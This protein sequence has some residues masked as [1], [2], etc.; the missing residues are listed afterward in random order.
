M[1]ARRKRT[2]SPTVGGQLA[3]ER[4]I[5]PFFTQP[6]MWFEGSAPCT[7]CHFANS[8]ES[9]HEMDLSNYAGIMKGADAL[10]EPPG[11]PIIKPGDWD[12]SVL[13]TRLRNNRMPPG[14]T[15][16]LDESNRDGP[17]VEAGKSK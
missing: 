2:P 5:L 13:R 3:F 16:M 15:F 17:I 12:G 7:S 4:D 14:W 10:S 6:N 11:V 1:P 8:E 9:A